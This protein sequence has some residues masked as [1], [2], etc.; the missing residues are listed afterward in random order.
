MSRM[1]PTLS[2][3][4]PTFNRAE[5]LK[6]TLHNLTS[7]VEF[8]NS[9]KIEIVISDNNSDDETELVSAYFT[10]LFPGKVIYSKNNHNINDKNFEKSLSLGNGDFLKLHNDSLIVRPGTLT[11]IIK[12]LEACVYEK[13]LIFFLNGKSKA[14][15]AVTI[16][17]NADTF[18]K[19]VSY[20]CTWIGGFGIWKDQ[21][22]ELEDLSRYAHLK[23]VQTDTLF[24]ILS[25]G[26]RAIILNE[27]YFPM[28]DVGARGGYNLSQ[29]FGKNYLKILKEN[30]DNKTISIESFNEEKKKIL[31]EHII[32][33]YFDSRH[34]F[35]DHGFF[36]YL[37]DYYDEPYFIDFINQKFFEFTA[38][39]T[40]PPNRE[41]GSI[42]ALWRSMN[43]HNETFMTKEFNFMNVSVGNHSYG[44]LDVATFNSTDEALRIGNFVSIAEEVKFI[45]GGNHS[46]EG[47]S[48]YPFRVKF[49][50]QKNEAWTKGPVIISDDVWIG[51]G[52]TILSGVTVGQGAI[53][54]ARSN[55]TR[56]IPPYAIAAGNPARIIKYRF[57]QKVIDKLIRVDFSRITPDLI[58]EISD[59]LYT[60][61]NDSNIDN[62]LKKLPLK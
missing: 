8:L 11:E 12:V 29:V 40:R 18:L 49:L 43:P 47:F 57:S 28:Q 6:K 36:E 31:L 37:G 41:T 50:D 26:K 3:C 35:S 13:P 1:K 44:G 10:R 59:E 33:F 21:F 25:Y 51:Y 17:T 54:A 22:N 48:T 14:N 34:K 20:N 62:F 56:S 60:P 46:Y 52:S 19:H 58:H 45:L 5:I 30:V 27:F 4:I 55:V 23:L 2:I 32:P 9:D 61:L 24:R 42:S 38:N 15:D 7:Q 16:C 53:I 39:D